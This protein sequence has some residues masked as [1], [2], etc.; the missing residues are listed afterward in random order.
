MPKAYLR[1]RVSFPSAE[2]VSVCVAFGCWDPSMATLSQA[3]Y[4]EE[5]RRE[6]T[7]TRAVHV[8]VSYIF[9][10]PFATLHAYRWG[11]MGQILSSSTVR[12]AASSCVSFPG[13]VSEYG[14]SAREVGC[15]QSNGQGSEELSDY[16]IRLSEQTAAPR[17]SMV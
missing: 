13:L 2:A 6:E 5:V 16:V 15:Q 3:V 9:T 8:A 11:H 10:S 1:F 4:Q 17:K 14:N 7:S 12:L